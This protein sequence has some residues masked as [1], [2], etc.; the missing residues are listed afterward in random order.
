MIKTIRYNASSVFSDTGL[1]KQTGWNKDS[2]EFIWV[3]LTEPTLQEEESVFSIFN[4]HPLPIEDSR[5]GKILKN[6]QEKLH[7]PKIEDYRDFLFLVFHEVSSK[8]GSIYFR[9]EQ[10]NAFIGKNFLITLTYK[11]FDCIEKCSELLNKNPQYAGNGPDFIL[12]IILDYIVEDYKSYTENLEEN[13]EHRENEVY[14]KPSQ[15][16]IN[17]LLKLKK[18]INKFNKIIIYQKEILSRLSHNEFKLITRDES[19]YYR[20]VYDHLIRV[21][22]SLEA[23]RDTIS[24]LLVGCMSVISNRLN[25]IMK[26]LTIITTIMMPLSLIAGIYGMNFR[27]MPELEWL[28]GYPFVIFLMVIITII[29][30]LLFKR[31]K[32]F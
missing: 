22:D 27:N 16:T 10:L 23:I 24:G 1:D 6:N 15:N 19:Y 12:H 8:P 9:Q 14:L 18:E 11:N 31:K 13:I 5:R 28:Y 25:E 21:Y 32:W 29:M 26:V 20:N 3:I 4:I 17:A 30:L 2:D 7:H